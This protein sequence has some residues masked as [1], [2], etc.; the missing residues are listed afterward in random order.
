[1]NKKSFLIA[2]VFSAL[3][4]PACSQMDMAQGAWQEPDIN[5]ISG[6]RADTSEDLLA[7]QG[8]WALVEQQGA[9]EPLYLHSSARKQVNPYNR[10]KKQFISEARLANIAGTKG[11][12]DIRF[13][14]LKLEQEG[15]R[16][17]P[18]PQD[19]AALAYIERG[20]ESF[21]IVALPDK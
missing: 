18:A 21:D 2:S 11:E 8:R 16:D 14:L 7:A 13:R 12:Q 4:L 17:F 20:D 5:S 15:G 6:V 9:Q 19:N 3:I 10:T 1:M